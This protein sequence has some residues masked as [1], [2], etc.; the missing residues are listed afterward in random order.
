MR[1]GTGYIPGSPHKATHSFAKV[2][3][4]GVD[5]S[6]FNR[7]FTHKTTFAEGY[8]IPFYVDEV[9]PG[10]TFAARLTGFLRL[11]TLLFPIMD[12]LYCDIQYW[13]VPNRLLW[14]NWIYMMGEQNNPGD[15]TNFTVPQ[16]AS[17][18]TFAALSLYDYMGIPPSTPYSQINNLLGRAYNFVWNQEYRDQN[19][20]NSVHLDTGNGPDTAS[21]YVLLRRGKRHD[22][23]T[24]ALPWPQKVNDGS[25]LNVPLTGT[26]PVIS[27]GSLPSLKDNS[28]VS[29]TFLG[30]VGTQNALIWNA[31][32]GHADQLH[33]NN[34]GLKT[35]LTQ[36]SGVTINE[37]RQSIQIQRMFEKDARGGTR[38]PELIKSH[39]GVI[40]PDFRLQ[41]P[42]LLSLSHHPFNIH[43]VPQTSGTGMTGETTPQANLAAYG[44][45]SITNSGFTKSFVEHGVILGLLS[46]R[47]DLTYQQGIE[48]SW[49]R[50]TR[51]DFAWPVLAHLG[52]QTI[53]NQ[54]IYVAGTSG[55][56]GV[57]GYQERYAEYRFKPSIVSGEFRSSYSTPLDA[58]HLAQNFGGAPTL[59]DTFIVENAPMSRILASGAVPQ[60]LADLFVDLK[61]VRPLPVY[62]VPGWMDHF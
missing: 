18:T 10:D 34:T 28:A 45:C 59:G 61:C 37:L 27:D 44:T 53:L 8:L 23:F 39:F 50:Q 9:L 33:W 17:S 21:N 46:V 49:F 30:Q 43:P 41:R 15:S 60:F 16:V 38:Y 5:R 3:V 36:A 54:E 22:Y 47:A 32:S 14:T 20:Q 58:W 11:S 12:N 29:G 35:D 55:D 7:S 62:S 1:R 19:M 24:S 48:R 40:S 25:T 2:P 51:Y 56:I 42:E 26:A 57:F 31:T 52:E 4:V 13:Y 6:V